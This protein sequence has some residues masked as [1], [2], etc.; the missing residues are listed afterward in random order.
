MKRLN[1]KSHRGYP[2]NATMMYLIVFSLYLASVTLQTTTF[3]VHYPHFIG[4]AIQLVTIMVMLCKLVFCDDLTDQQ[5]ILELGILV[6]VVMVALISGGHY[7]VTTILLVLG[8]RNVKFKT[9]IKL[10]LIIVGGIL[11]LAFI[12]SQLGIIQNIRYATAE[13]TR[14]A[15]GV[16]YTTDFAAHIFYLSCAYLYLKSHMFRIIDYVPVLLALFVIYWFTKTMTDVLALVVLLVLFTLYIYRK[17]LR[18]NWLIAIVLRYAFFAMPVISI[19]IFQLSACFNSRDNF[20]AKANQLL[21]N[22]LALGY[23]AILAYGIKLFGQSPIYANGWGGSRVG[24]LSRGAGNLTYFY[25]DSS[26]LN[27]LISYGILFTLVVILGTSFF[28]YRRSKYND[29]LLPI[30][31]VAIAISAGFDQHLMEVTYNV[32][33]LSIFAVLPAYNIEVGPSFQKSVIFNEKI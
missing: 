5:I 26:Y 22:R 20:F 33:F 25:V 10:Y 27:M 29:Y 18:H 9:I 12:S 13:G 15:F 2:L 23:D 32:F 3:G 31:F 30:I 21:S 4:S 16:V 14:E 28:L 8:A 17:R 6:L 24:S 11:L 19:V 1:V 7:L